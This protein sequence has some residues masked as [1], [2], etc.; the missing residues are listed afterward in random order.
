MLDDI[1]IDPILRIRK[2]VAF[3]WTL[4]FRPNFTTH[5]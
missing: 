4:N 5:N 3:G 1:E 2:F